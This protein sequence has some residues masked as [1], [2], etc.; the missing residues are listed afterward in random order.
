MALFPSL[1]RLGLLDRDEPALRELLAEV[2]RANH[3]AGEYLVLAVRLSLGEALSARVPATIDKITSTRHDSK[4]RRTLLCQMLADALAVHGAAE[5][6]MQLIELAVDSE[7]L[8]VVWLERSVTLD[9]LRPLPGFQAAVGT[10]QHR[11]RAI[12]AEAGEP[13]FGL[14]KSV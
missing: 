5:L 11:A 10:L 9:A 2:E 13:P 14:H 12:W 8:D 3:P 4:R 6:A 7:L 1:L